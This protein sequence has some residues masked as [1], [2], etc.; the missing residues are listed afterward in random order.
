MPNRP[1][2][3][4]TIPSSEV[5]IRAFEF[6]PLRVWALFF[7]VD[8]MKLV[9][10]YWFNVGTGISSRRAEEALNILESCKEISADSS[11]SPVDEALHYK[12][13]SRLVNVLERARNDRSM[14]ISLENRHV[15]ASS[16]IYL[17]STGMSAI[18]YVH[19]YLLRWST[20]NSK[21]VVFGVPFGAVLNVLTEFGPGVQWFGLGTEYKELEAFLKTEAEEGRP[22]REIWTEV[23][24]NPLLLSADLNHLRRLADRYKFAL[25][26][27]DTIAGFC[28][29][30]VLPVADIVV[31]SLTKG[32]SGYADVMGGSAVLNPSSPLAEDL[33]PIFDQHYQNELFDADAEVLLKNSEDYLQ[34]SKILNENAAGLVQYIHS[35]AKEPSS[36]VRSVFYP[37]TSPTLSNYQAV[38]RPVTEDFIPG[39]GC[40]FTVELVDLDATIAFY[41]NLYVHHGPHLGAN[42]TLA[43]PYTQGIFAKK[44]Q[45]MKKWNLFPTQIR[46]AVGLEPIEQLKP[47]FAHALRKADETKKC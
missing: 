32:F 27:D 41:D 47:V 36:T 42:R 28:N 44:L 6:G 13:R 9:H 8:K 33:K 2:G 23:P 40:V 18:Y 29:I 11:P 10:R 7:P 35:L 16:D 37:T 45:E 24:S 34:R 15:S 22:V 1:D 25:V 39:Y 4:D 5:S 12:L 43:M 17:Y 14:S 30:D 21:T 19:S 3:L 38:M 26:V 20:P 46:I 31:T